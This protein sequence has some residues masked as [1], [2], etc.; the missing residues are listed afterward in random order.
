MSDLDLAAR[1]RVAIAAAREAGRHLADLY[2]RRDQLVI[3]TKGPNDFVSR[4]DKE[5][6]AIVRGAISVAFPAD[7]FL[8]EETGYSGPDNA[9]CLWVVDP[10]D[11]TTNFL[12]GAHN[13]CVSIGVMV[14]GVPTIGI[15]YDPLRDEMFEARK[16]H[17]ARMNDA[18]LAVSSVT[19]M[20]DAVC[21][22]GYTPRLP[23]PPFITKTT[24][25]LE[26]GV[27][28][29]QLGAG[30]LML[31]YVAA[32]RIDLYWEFHMWPWD[33]MGGIVLIEEAGGRVAPFPDHEGDLAEG[34]R[35]VAGPPQLYPALLAAADR[36]IA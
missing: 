7:R 33:V 8:G 31:A 24:H 19:R 28:F 17:G 9:R 14:D 3:E 36:P 20:Q 35:L 21:A 27:A 16:G 29:R 23:L 10:L 13:W 5:A 25:L 1:H 2:R 15:V 18:P 11:G 6:E 34:G 32:G 26:T 4:A 22:L 30:A 12:K